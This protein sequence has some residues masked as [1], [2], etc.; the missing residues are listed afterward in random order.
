MCIVVHFISILFYTIFVGITTVFC[1]LLVNKGETMGNNRAYKCRGRRLRRPENPFSSTASL[2]GRLAVR[3]NLKRYKRQ[4]ESSNNKSE[5]PRGVS[6]L[7]VPLTGIEPVRILLRGILSPLCLPIPPQRH[8]YL[9]DKPPAYGFYSEGFFVRLGC[10]IFSLPTSG[11]VN[12]RPRH[13]LRPRLFRPRRRSGSRPLCL[14][15]PP[16]RHR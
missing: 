5:A 10:P 11:C 16:Q 14:P 12:Y 8:I 9:Y 13:T 2:R 6:L 15:I 7:L 4:P 1:V 3:G